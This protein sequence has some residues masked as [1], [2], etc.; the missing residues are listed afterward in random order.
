MGH[1]YVRLLLADRGILR[2]QLQAYAACGDPEIQTV[3]RQN[4]GVLWQTVAEI[5]GADGDATRRWFADGMLIN[6]I[7]SISNASTMEDFLHAI[8]G[9]EFGPC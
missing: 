8:W 5:S 4:Y 6:V 2:L 9:G 3:V 7:A 1:A